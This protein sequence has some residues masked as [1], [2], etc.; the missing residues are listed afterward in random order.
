MYASR[1]MIGGKGA[2]PGRRNG[3]KYEIIVSLVWGG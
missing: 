2:V 1:K 3:G